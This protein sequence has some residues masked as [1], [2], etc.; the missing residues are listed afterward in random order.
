ML[1]KR[2]S[3]IILL[4]ETH[5]DKK[6]FKH[7]LRV[8][9]YASDMALQHT[10]VDNTDAF[11]VGVAHDLIEDTACTPEEMEDILGTHLSSSV[12]ILTKDDDMP[13]GEYIDS[14]LDSNDDIAILV[15]RADIK[16][17]LSQIDT[18]TDK[19]K[20]KYLPILGKIM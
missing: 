16:D 7:A 3:K 6:T 19:L 11:L 17:H 14:V 5:Y 4:A 18:L 2:L 15:K 8:A 13:Y 12:Y 10:R 20:E 1:D 9:C